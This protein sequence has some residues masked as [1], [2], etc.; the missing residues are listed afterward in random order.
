MSLSHDGETFF[1]G[2]QIVGPET[3]PQMKM[4]VGKTGAPRYASVIGTAAPKLRFAPVPNASFVLKLT[5]D[6]KL[7]ALSTSDTENWLLTDHPNIYLYA[8][9]VEMERFLLEDARTPMWQAALEN[10]LNQLNIYTQRI[11]FGGQI[12]RRPRQAFGA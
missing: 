5:Y 6:T 7:V 1:G 3:L 2:L 11:E 12:V 9:L 4:Q 8:S 10:A